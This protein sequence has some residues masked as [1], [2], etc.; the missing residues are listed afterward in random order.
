MT[1][2]NKIILLSIL[3]SCISTAIIIGLPKFFSE[4]EH[5]IEQ[6]VMENTRNFN[7]EVNDIYDEYKLQ[8]FQTLKTLDKQKYNEDSIVKSINEIC[9]KKMKNLEKP[10]KLITSYKMLLLID[11]GTYKEIDSLKCIRYAEMVIKKQYVDSVYEA[12]KRASELKEN[13]LKSLNKPCK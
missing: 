2:F 1:K 4:P 7:G 11:Y 9:D 10:F 6:E 3:L 13:Q 5:I 12:Y 8:L